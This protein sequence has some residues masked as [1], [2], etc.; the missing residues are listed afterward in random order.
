M[1]TVTNAE[2]GGLGVVKYKC[3][4]CEDYMNVLFM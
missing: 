1:K 4:F 2:V 3:S